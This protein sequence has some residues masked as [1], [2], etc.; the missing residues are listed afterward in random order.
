MIK[1]K[2]VN[3]LVKAIN[4][5]TKNDV[6]P[7]V[8]TA[9]T[10][11]ETKAPQFSAGTKFFNELYVDGIKFPGN[12]GALKHAVAT[13]KPVVIK[14]NWNYKSFVRWALKHYDDT[15]E[16][17]H[18]KPLPTFKK[19]LEREIKIVDAKGYNVDTKKTYTVMVAS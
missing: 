18:A 6:L 1:E 15:K 10:K 14:D 19:F 2:V 4:E 3:Q 9:G 11:T 8:S 17:Y 7:T 5:T 16:C 12:F 13:K